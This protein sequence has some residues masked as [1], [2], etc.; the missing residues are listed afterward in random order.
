MASSITAGGATITKSPR[1]D[2]KPDAA[3]GLVPTRPLVMRCASASEQRT[4]V[5]PRFTFLDPA[6]GG[7]SVKL[8]QNVGQSWG[9]LAE[10]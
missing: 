8:G 6:G 9:N 3:G 7:G 2:Q 4:A 5:V 1:F 10:A